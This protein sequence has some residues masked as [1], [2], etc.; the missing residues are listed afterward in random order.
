MFLLTAVDLP[1]IYFRSD[2]L[3]IWTN[4]TKFAYYTN[5]VYHH[6]KILLVCNCF[7]MVVDDSCSYC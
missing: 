5:N 3:Q 4:L 2:Y 1:L 6:E 7:F